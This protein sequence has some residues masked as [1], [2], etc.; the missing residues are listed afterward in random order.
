MSTILKVTVTSQPATIEIEW[1][2][3]VR[4]TRR[5]VHL[6]RA[7]VFVAGRTETLQGWDFHSG[8]SPEGHKTYKFALA[9]T[10]G[11]AGYEPRPEEVIAL[12]LHVGNPPEPVIAGAVVEGEDCVCEKLVAEAINFTGAQI[13]GDIQSVGQA[14]QDVNQGVQTAGA[15]VQTSSADLKASYDKAMNWLTGFPFQVSDGLTG[16]PSTLGAAASASAVVDRELRAVL[17]RVPGIGGVA[18]TVSALDRSFQAVVVDGAQTWAWRPQSYAVLSDIGAGVTG[19]QASLATFAGTVV[20][21]ILPLVAGLRPLFPENAVNP[22]E[23]DAARAILTG[24][25]PAFVSEVGTD[26]GPR[27]A[28]ARS[29]LT[30]GATQLQV[31]GMLLGALGQPPAGIDLSNP[32]KW[33]APPGGAA[34]Y[35]FDPLDPSTWWPPSED[36]V[37]T[38]DDEQ[39]LTNYRIGF[40]RVGLLVTQFATVYVHGQTGDR[41]MLIVILQRALDASAEAAQAVFD[42]LDSVNLGEDERQVIVANAATGLTVEDAVSWAATFPT[43]EAAPLLQGGGKLGARSVLSR[44]QALSAAIT[45]VQGLG[46]PVGLQHPRVVFALKLLQD[47]FTDIETAAGPLT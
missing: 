38:V 25:L 8:P 1:Q 18:A 31:L 13:E 23:I 35:I 14:V 34:A 22:D 27:I 24:S 21:E 10:P 20:D 12:E 11:G 47:A 15:G 41:G 6:G 26:G 28:R 43:D 7:R 16:G 2:G 32:L 30:D 9:R 29:L 40:D 4:L 42:A 39:N 37:V 19:R 46:D 33:P 44:T 36:Y 17:G 45:A 5:H 3:D